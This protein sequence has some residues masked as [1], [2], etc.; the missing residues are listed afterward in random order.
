MVDTVGGEGT[1]TPNTSL[2]RGLLS[3]PGKR[4]RVL[5]ISS[6][7]TMDELATSLWSLTVLYLSGTQP[8]HSWDW[9]LHC[10]AAR[11]LDI[12]IRKDWILYHL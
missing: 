8:V 11:V 4:S 1:L 9:C 10:Y 3:E 6:R 2:W 7:I 12:L 5:V